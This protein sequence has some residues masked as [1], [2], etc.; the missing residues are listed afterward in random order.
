MFSPYLAVG[1]EVYTDY[2]ATKWIKV[3]VY[4]G[5]GYVLWN[6]WALG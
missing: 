5:D 2:I 1:W 6:L 3:F 4:L